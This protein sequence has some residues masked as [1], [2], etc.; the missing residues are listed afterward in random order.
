MLDMF[1]GA[2]GMI[3]LA[4][5]GGVALIA[6][7]GLALV[8]N[9]RPDPMAKFSETASR[10]RQNQ[11]SAQTLRRAA[12]GLDMAALRKYAKFLEPTDEKELSEARK[13]LVLAG[14]HGKSA[15]RDLHAIQFLLAISG[16]LFSLLLIFV[17]LPDKLNGTATLAAVMV[18]PMLIGYFMPRRWV[19]QRATARQEEI[20]AGFPDALDMM[21][22][23]VEAGQS[24][25]Q[26][27]QRV[28]QEIRPAYPALSEE[29]TTVGD[30]VRAGR[31]R[32][33]VLREMAK[34]VDLTDI[35]SFVTVMVQAAT[36]GT[37]ITQALRIF[38]AEMRDKRIMRAEE[39]ANLLPTKMTLGTMMFTVP[40][41]LIILIG[42]SVVG[43]MTELNAGAIMG[44]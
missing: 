37:S 33:E 39:K 19:E 15:V 29:L 40:P 10:A 1:Q 7:A 42:P 2:F 4:G 34:R 12:T 27:I 35:T 44:N 28:A 18:A 8:A 22:I 30:Q 38:A 25:D 3:M 21:L 6:V 5:I 36:Y 9:G 26:S 11:G 17:I 31:E 20:M 24:L 43:V 14:Y 32:G 23:C 41:L 13:K 16:L